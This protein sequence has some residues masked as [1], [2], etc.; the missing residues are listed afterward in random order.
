[1]IMVHLMDLTFKA[2]KLNFIS[3][4]RESISISII[5]VIINEYTRKYLYNCKM[6]QSIFKYVFL[7]VYNKSLHVSSNYLS[8]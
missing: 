5:T 6:L 1:M 2:L 7:E 8:V 4:L 3:E